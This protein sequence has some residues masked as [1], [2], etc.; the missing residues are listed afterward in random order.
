MTRA[1]IIIK[2]NEIFADIIDE[3]PVYLSETNT[4][5]DIEGWDS[6]TNIQLIVDIEKNLNIKFTSDE[7]FSWKNVGEMID[8][9]LIKK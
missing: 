4:S 7:I 3:G 1:E 5:N 2:L 9:I 6:L 8:C